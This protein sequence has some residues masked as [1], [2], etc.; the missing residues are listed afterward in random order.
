MP[1]SPRQPC[2]TPR[3]PNTTDRGRCLTCRTRTEQVRGSA[4]QRGYDSYWSKTFVPWF[5]RQLAGKGI[6]PACGASLPGG[7]D[8]RPF[9]RCAQE[10]R[11]TIEKLHVDHNPPLDPWERKHRAR[12]CDPKRVGLL[13][14]EDH[15]R[16]TNQEMQRAG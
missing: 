3:C 6:A 9:S 14:D 1:S 10:G 8:M 12:V 4:S 13:C 11:L 7:P 15:G 2:S 5:K 16:K